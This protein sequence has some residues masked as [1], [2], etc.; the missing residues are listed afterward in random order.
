MSALNVGNPLNIVLTSVDTG[1]FTQKKDLM[2]VVNV[3]NFL[4]LDSI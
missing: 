2:S 1:E 4:R 3:G